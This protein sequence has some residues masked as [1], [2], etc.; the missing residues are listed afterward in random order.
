MA[1]NVT[2]RDLN[3]EQQRLNR[4]ERENANKQAGISSMIGT[5][6]NLGTTAL[7]LRALTKAPGEPLFGRTITEGAKKLLPWSS[8]AAATAAPAYVDI[9]GTPMVAAMNMAGEGVTGAAGEAGGFMA[10]LGSPLGVLSAGLAGYELGG[11]THESAIGAGVGAAIGSVIPGVGTAVGAFLGGT[12]GDPLGDI[13]E[14]VIEFLGDTGGDIISG[15]GDVVSSI[16]GFVGDV[17]GTFVCTEMH[18]QRIISHDI[19]RASIKFGKKLDPIIMDGYR[20]WGYAFSRWMK[21]SRIATAIIT[22]FMLP[23][24]EN[25]AYHEGYRDKPNYLGAIV[26]T[27]LY[28]ICWVIGHYKARKAVMA[29]E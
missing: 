15:I 26:H 13:G 6:G 2:S 17:F 1:F 12:F 8:T 29:H 28:P 22:S 21:K 11:G 20:T 3:L 24:A 7:T 5:V 9:A 25:M 16:G 27:I 19:F 10:G 23:W 4:E 14:D 18:R